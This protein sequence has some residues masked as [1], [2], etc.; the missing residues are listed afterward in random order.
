MEASNREV[1]ERFLEPEGGNTE[2]ERMRN[3]E[4]RKRRQKRRAPG[5]QRKGNEDRWPQ[6]RAG[7]RRLQG[8]MEHGC[9]RPLRTGGY[10]ESNELK[11]EEDFF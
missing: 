10:L 4:I 5:S 8:Q 2:L 7:L 11:Q 1:R 9:S 3:S 6:G